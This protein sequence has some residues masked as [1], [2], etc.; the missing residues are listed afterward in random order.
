MNSSI[1][2]KSF[3]AKRSVAW[4]FAFGI[5]FALIGGFFI[6]Q[7]M[8]VQSITTATGGGAVSIDTTSASGGSGTYTD[9]GTISIL[10]QAIGEI[11]LGLH[12]FTVPSGWQIDPGSVITVGANW[13]LSGLSLSHPTTITPDNSTQFSININAVS[14]N[15]VAT[16]SFQGLRV[17][18]TGTVPST[19]NIL[20]TVGII[21]GVTNESTNFGTL[22]TVP[23]APEHFTLT[24]DDTTPGAGETVTAT[25]TARDQFENVTTTYSGSKNIAFFFNNTEVAAAH[26]SPNST[27]P[28]AGGSN[29]GATIA[30]TF[31][32][33]VSA[34]VSL[35]FSKTET[36]DIDVTEQGGS[37][38]TTTGNVDRDVSVTVSPGNLASM[39]VDAIGAQ[40]AGTLFTINVNAFDGFGN[41]TTKD[42]DGTALTASEDITVSSSAT[43]SNN[44]T[45]PL[46]NGNDLTNGEA[47]TIDFSSGVFTSKNI[48]LYD[49]GETPTITVAHGLVNVI[50]PVVTVGAGA[51]DGYIVTTQ[52]A[53]T[54][55]VDNLFSVTVTPVDAYDNVQ[56]TG[57]T[58]GQI[59]FTS[60][61]TNAP[62]NT[63]PTIL[64]SATL[65][66]STGAKTTTGTFRL[67]DASETP[68]ITATDNADANK[69][70]TTSAITVNGGVE[71]ELIFTQ[72]PAGSVSGVALTTQ[73]IVTATD[74]FG[75]ISTSF[76]ELVTLTEGSAGT[77]TNNT[78]VAVNGVAT[79][80]NVIYTAAVDGESVT[81]TA[82]DDDLVNTNIPTVDATPFNSDVV[83]TT[84]VFSQQP[85]AGANSGAVLA[86]QPIVTAQGPNN[87]TDTGF[88]ELIT[89]ISDVGTIGGTTAVNAIAGV[90]TFTNVTHTATVDNQVT[91]LS[92]NDE[93]G[94]G[95]NLAS[96]NAS[97]FTTL[98]VATKLLVTTNV[99]SPQEAGVD[100]TVQPVVKYVD[101]SDVVD[102]DI[103]AD[104]IIVSE[105]GAGSLNGTLTVTAVDGVV[106][107]AGLDYTG[108]TEGE[109]ITL[110]FTDDA[111]NTVNLS[112]SPVNGTTF[113]VNFLNN[114]YVDPAGNNANSGTS[115]SPKLTVQ[116][117]L[118]SVATG[119]TVIVNAGTYDEQLTISRAVT[120]QG[121]NQATSIIAPTTAPSAGVYDVQVDA[122]SVTIENLTFDFDGADGDRGASNAGG[123]AVSESGGATP[124][125]NVIIQNN[126]IY[127]AAVAIQSGL[128]IDVDG[129]NISNNTIHLDADGDGNLASWD[130]A[131]IYINP[132]AGTG[133]VTISGNT[134][135]GHI[136]YGIAFE[137]SN[138]T[139]SGNTIDN[140]VGTADKAGIRY[141]DWYSNDHTGAVISGNTIDSM[142][143]GI[144][145]DSGQ[146][147][148]T[149]AGDIISNTITN[150]TTV[151]IW[152][153]VG[154]TAGL[155]I[156]NNNTPS[157][158]D[159]SAIGATWSGNTYGNFSSNT[160]YPIT[161]LLA[162]TK[163]SV[164]ST[165][166]GRMDAGLSTVSVSSPTVADNAAVSTVTITVVNAS[167]TPLSGIAN[168][169]F[170]ISSTG[171]NNTIVQP[172]NP[173]NGSGVTTGTIKS[174]KAEVKTISV[175]V[176]GVAITQTADA[177]FT[178]APIDDYI[179][180]SGIIGNQ[181]AGTSFEV[182]IQ[183]RDVNDNFITS[184][185]DASE[186]INITLG[187]VDGAAS[188]LS[189]NTSGGVATA[190]IT[191]T[192]AQANQ[193]LTF[194]GVTSTKTTGASNTFTITPGA[195]NAG[196]S[197]L[198]VNTNSLTVNSGTASSTA[199]ITL[200][201][202]YSNLITG[203]TAVLLSTGT[204][205]LISGTTDNGNGTYTATISSTKAEVKTLSATGDTVTITQT[206]A[207]TFN[208]GAFASF[209][210]VPATTAPTTGTAF[211]VTVTAA[212]AFS[213]AVTSFT[214]TV[215]FSTDATAPYTLPA[216]TVFAGSDNGVK[217][218]SVIFN[219]VE[220]NKTIT[221]VD[222]ATGLK[223][224]TSV[225]ISPVTSDP[226]APT[227]VSWTPTDGSTNVSVS[228]SIT[229]NF[230]EALNPNTVDNTKF[231]IRKYSDDT[232]APGSLNVVLQGGNT[233]VIIT[234]NTPLL[235]GTQYYIHVVSTITDVSGNQF[236]SSWQS[237]E[238]ADHEFTTVPALTVDDVVLEQGTA[239]AFD[240]FASGWRYRFEVTSNDTSE[241]T[242]E[243]RLNDWA[244]S[245]GGGTVTTTL[246]TRL[247]FD[248]SSG[249]SFA[250]TSLTD[251]DVINGSG[252]IVSR[253]VGSAVDYSESDT[254]TITG[255][256]NDTGTA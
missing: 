223:T 221:A 209:N 36:A 216:S 22:T 124:V 90:A 147:T 48:I 156:T 234:P 35:V 217:T 87:V 108:G 45:I 88:T 240:S 32:N 132:N 181:V 83:A 103:D 41:A 199:T 5:T 186:T 239:T 168:T 98:V 116:V 127:S 16:L 228:P 33:G 60:T 24:V 121:V 201:D 56:Q 20:H 75:N 192:V 76:T 176:G 6:Y 222:L 177:T 196:T 145:V 120:L 68:T 193:T 160:N 63:V 61:A 93:D 163:G 126:I 46:Y 95:T 254:I 133:S 130:V 125:E 236:G 151:G 155:N 185:G 244:K 183:A 167:S 67:V 50:T 64:A 114:I 69:N 70:G 224:G 134:I 18:P 106:T 101:A 190:T 208:A 171:T 226:N 172:A 92:A 253:A 7:A 2:S 37:N 211:N 144:W 113:N 206:Q 4:L 44:A 184:G 238:K 159:N 105:N 256:D 111:G 72:Q 99:T 82:N 197:S 39:T 51:F 79:F 25:M 237:G 173:T 248:S 1:I 150:A 227:I 71:A 102:V 242:L 212:D 122:S 9:L 214:G 131:G 110:I 86:Q 129:L 54:Q 251:T 165:P 200:R 250:A 21:T 215:L 49:A 10:E 42:A 13:A 231:R 12:T 31:T 170:V 140:T 135:D 249:D 161:Y 158:E 109:I 58:N 29:F 38:L 153:N 243:L 91:T 80:T 30:S 137:A 174:T 198:T 203:A 118:N 169:K 97:T 53:G 40:V 202:Q 195:V 104:Q 189:V 187:Q 225:G 245:G 142:P 213:N 15:Q 128:N 220:S 143:R 11:G 3:F 47:D 52:N 94:V 26:L 178:P 241:N 123:I 149:F 8:A 205:N 65:D 218:A 59:N 188:G 252:L 115:L 17:R 73:P 233:S 100:F 112:A 247:L 78:Q 55:N 28:T 229:L 157:A 180:T 182:V 89:L 166:V 107:F 207:V 179:I 34:G 43:A 210:V 232:D 219:V 146:G 74:Q 148:G 57:A 194:T 141:I 255:L 246:N 77:L 235:Y 27:N 152:V 119:G 96:V 85:T 81:L 117:G 62:D 19:G 23:G 164:D 191:L 139:V 162:G 204:D 66:L 230:S 175:T 84:L 136:G 154:A 138:V 14:N